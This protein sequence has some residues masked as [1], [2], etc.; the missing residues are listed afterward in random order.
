MIV[1]PLAPRLR[2]AAGDKWRKTRAVYFSVTGVLLITLS[3]ATGSNRRSSN[4]QGRSSEEFEG[5]VAAEGVVPTEEV[6]KTP[7]EEVLLTWKSEEEDSQENPVLDLKQQAS[8]SLIGSS[9]SSSEGTSP[10]LSEGVVATEEVSDIE[11]PVPENSEREVLNDSK[12]EEDGTEEK[13][14]GEVYGWKQQATEEDSGVS[15]I[16]LLETA[17]SAAAMVK[18]RASLTLF[19]EHSSGGV[20][21]AG[22]S[23]NEEE[24]DGGGS[25]GSSDMEIVRRS[26]A[27][28]PEVFTDSPLDEW[29][30]AAAFAQQIGAEVLRIVGRLLIGGEDS[31]TKELFGGREPPSAYLPLVRWTKM[32]LFVAILGYLLVSFGVSQLVRYWRQRSPLKSPL[33]DNNGK[34]PVTDLIKAGG[35]GQDPNLERVLSRGVIHHQS[36]GGSRSKFFE[37]LPSAARVCF[38][39]PPAWSLNGLPEPPHRWS[40]EEEK[41]GSEQEPVLCAEVFE[42]KDMDSL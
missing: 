9:I 6:G 17:S 27:K 26:A 2:G 15:G 18:T 19:Q 37:Y 35:G 23:G 41:L 29:R 30:K 22:R 7:E 3:A 12:P 42:A 16:S 14:D 25:R 21:A 34:P 32:Y 24:L 5:V 39:L 38:C 13:K 10:G 20:M 8:D 40:R 11:P 33:E 1:S 4:T 36:G 28:P 31:R